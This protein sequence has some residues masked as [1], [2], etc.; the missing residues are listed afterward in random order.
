MA[1]PIIEGK[2]RLVTEFTPSD[3]K[4]TKI[5]NVSSVL[6]NEMS[7]LRTAQVDILDGLVTALVTFLLCSNLLASSVG[8]ERASVSPLLD[9]I[10]MVVKLRLQNDFVS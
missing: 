10:D 7:V 8:A 2:D 9:F 4:P 5:F 3:M 1:V 6:Q